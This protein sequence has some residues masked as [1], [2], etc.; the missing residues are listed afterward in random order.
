MSS[1]PESDAILVSNILSEDDHWELDEEM[2]AQLQFASRPLD[3]DSQDTY[4]AWV[5]FTVSRQL[6]PLY[7]ER[8]R[9]FKNLAD[10]ADGLLNEPAVQQIRGIVDQALKKVQ[11]KDLRNLGMHHHN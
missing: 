7:G 4:R 9:K 11:F 2:Q 8:G 3:A 5:L 1:S 6:R 10:A